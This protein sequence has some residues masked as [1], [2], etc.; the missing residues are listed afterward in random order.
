MSLTLGQNG[1]YINQ[2]ENKSA[3]PSLQGFFYICEYFGVTPKEFFDEGN[4]YPEK[5]KDLI[6]E[7]KK[8]D[9]KALAHILGIMRELNR[10]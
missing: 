7:A 4:A 6:A 2:I 5:L 3:L 8:L 9:E 1:S 10:K